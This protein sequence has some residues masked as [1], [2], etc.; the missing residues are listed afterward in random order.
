MAINLLARRGMSCLVA[1]LFTL[2]IPGAFAQQVDADPSVNQGWPA[3]LT[4]AMAKETRKLRTSKVVLGD[5]LIKTRLAGKRQ[6]EPQPIEDG[7]YLTTDIRAGAPLECWAFTTV[8]DL[9]TIA[10]NIAE[11]SMLA[12]EQAYGPLGD[13]TLYHVEAGAYDGAPYLALE[14]FFAMG[15]PPNKRVGLTKVRVAV[16]DELS[17]VCAHNFLGYR[18]T[19]ANA[20]EQ[21][22]REAKF[23]GGGPAPYY[24][25]IVL[26]KI[27]EQTIGV[28]RSTFTL[29]AEGDTQI[30]ILESSLVPVDGTTLSI[31]DTWYS[32]FSRPDGTLINQQV[33]KSENGELTMNIA[34][35]PQG[36]GAWSVS[37]LLQGK[38]ISQE[39]NGAVRP[40]SELGQ[41]MAVEALLADAQREVTTLDVWVPAADPTQFLQAQ[42]ALD[43]AGRDEGRGRLTMGPLTMSA[44]F[45]RSGS[46]LNAGMQAGA[47]QMELERI[48][49][50]GTPH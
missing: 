42:V 26:Q 25:E 32:G 47:A 43:P 8:V 24:E 11:Q 44:R 45:D 14:W 27:G 30:N 49:V 3:W 21:F 19:F 33:A 7:W 22:V 13:R 40:V 18:E 17:L 38:E 15:E 31:S 34:L 6:G 12:G 41:M 48:W 50:R 9:A 23:D 29:D 37:G 28:S 2:V 35:E 4:E 39:L 5:G 1:A 20:F 16:K 46:L 10:S 36:G